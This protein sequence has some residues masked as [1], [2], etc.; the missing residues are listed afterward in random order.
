MKH[1]TEQCETFLP[2]NEEI[3]YIVFKVGE[4]NLENAAN[5]TISENSAIL[6]SC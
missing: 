2:E 1:F 4:G 5:L 6:Y 3:Q